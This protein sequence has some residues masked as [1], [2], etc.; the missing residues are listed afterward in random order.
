M[1]V[2]VYQTVP[3]VYDISHNLTDLTDHIE[4]KKRAYL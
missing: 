1:K 2:R 3:K 4:P